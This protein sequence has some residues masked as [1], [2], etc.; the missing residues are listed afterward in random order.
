M[1]TLTRNIFEA[2]FESEGMNASDV[3]H[4]F[5]ITTDMAMNNLKALENR[6]L[7]DS[8]GQ[9]PFVTYKVTKELLENKAKSI[10]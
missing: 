9:P 4:F 1:P 7:L 8:E 2:V 10:S 5:K 6:N 3:S